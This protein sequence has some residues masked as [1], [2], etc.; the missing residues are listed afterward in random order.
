MSSLSAFC[1]HISHRLS[2]PLKADLAVAA[3]ARSDAA[4][5]LKSCSFSYFPLRRPKRCE[6][7]RWKPGILN[8]LKQLATH[9]GLDSLPESLPRPNLPSTTLPVTVLP[10]Q[11]EPVWSLSF[12]ALFPPPA[13][14]VGSSSIDPPFPLVGKTRHW[15]QMSAVINNIRLINLQTSRSSRITVIP[16][17]PGTQ[18]LTPLSPLRG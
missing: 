3:A 10:I 13:A 1:K 12:Q 17:Q 18:S 14:S 7:W 6:W 8:L 2:H 16:T 9:L 5:P 4:T 11:I 15:G